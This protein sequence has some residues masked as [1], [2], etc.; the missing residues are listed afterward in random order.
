M[1][2]RDAAA[3]LGVSMSP[4]FRLRHHF[5]QAVQAQQP[6]QVSGLLEAD[7]TYFRQS[8]KGRGK[9]TRPTRIDDQV[10]SPKRGKFCIQD[11]GNAMQR[12][13]GS[14]ASGV[15]EDEEEKSCTQI[16][17]RSAQ[18]RGELRVLGERYPTAPL[19]RDCGT[20]L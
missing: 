9:M 17:T 5:L 16:Q 13:R 14:A 2:V 18:P 7:E 11:D 4:A 19:F 20:T 8:Q 15:A 3:A 10:A 1:T 6:L 12:L